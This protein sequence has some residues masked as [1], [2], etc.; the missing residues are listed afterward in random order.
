MK[1]KVILF[2]LLIAL[3]TS[4]KGL[5]T[6]SPTKRYAKE[7]ADKEFSFKYKKG[8]AEWSEMF[9]KTYNKKV[10]GPIKNN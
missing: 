2:L 10:K 5:H 3:G 9:D 8:W 4:C 7:H 6:V 1:N